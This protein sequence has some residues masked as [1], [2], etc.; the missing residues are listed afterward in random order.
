MARETTGKSQQDANVRQTLNRLIELLNRPSLPPPPIT[1]DVSET[2]DGTAY[3]VEIAAPGLTA[4]EIAVSAS[5]DMLTVEVAPRQPAETEQ[6]T[7][8]T[9]EM[10]RQPAA[11]VFTFPTPVDLDQV[12]ARLA[13][14]I[15]R[16]RAPK[17]EGA[18]SREIKVK[19]A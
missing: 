12:D 14:G 1:A 5:G 13:Q 18:P 3:V 19:A 17:A 9:Q 10:P 4:D 15:L 16:I 7:Y 11:R 6:R 2:A 8:L